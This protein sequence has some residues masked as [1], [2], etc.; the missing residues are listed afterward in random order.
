MI[1]KLFLGFG[2]KCLQLCHGLIDV[3]E[4]SFQWN[5]IQIVSKTAGLNWKGEQL[6]LG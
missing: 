4:S 2:N 3:F 6:I 5:G 1:M